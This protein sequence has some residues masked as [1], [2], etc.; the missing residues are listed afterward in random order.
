M[1]ICNEKSL[2]V[3]KEL[4]QNL[5]EIKFFSALP[6]DSQKI[7]CRTALLSFPTSNQSTGKAPAPH[8][9]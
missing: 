4:K 3:S 5:R 6:R 7:M 8:A 9:T 2:Q 1:P